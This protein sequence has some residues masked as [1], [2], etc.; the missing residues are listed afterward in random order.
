MIGEFCGHGNYQHLVKYEKISIIFYAIVENY[1][2]AS[3]IDPRKAFDIFEEFKLES[4]SCKFIGKFDDIT[5][6][7]TKLTEL[8]KE[9]S[10]ASISSE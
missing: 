7:K 2:I 6:F 5:T 9:I 3:C 10:E 8:Y 1:S 4:V